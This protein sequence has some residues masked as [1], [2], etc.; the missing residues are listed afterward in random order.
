MSGGAAADLP[1]RRC[2]GIL[3]LNKDGLVWIGR[4]IPKAHDTISRHIWQ[5]PQ[6]GI[7]RGEDPEQAARRELREETGAGN[8]EVIAAT[9]GWLTYDLPENLI[10]IALRGR[11]RGQRQKWFAMRFLGD[12]KDFCLEPEEGHK[13]EFDAWRWATLGEA[14]GLVVPFKRAVYEELVRCFAPLASPA[15]A[16]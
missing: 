1:Y 7:D 15:Q 12:D 16:A 8:A 9:A 6:G 11:Y 13:Q 14:P 4:R 2:V 10:G 3:L 5:M